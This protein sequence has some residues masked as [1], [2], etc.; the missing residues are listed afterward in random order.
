MSQYLCCQGYNN[1][2]CCLKP[3]R[4]CESSCPCLCLCIE[5]H[6]CCPVMYTRYHV[7]DMNELQ[8]DPCDNRLIWCNNCC[9]C[10][11][12]KSNTILLE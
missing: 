11:S 9:Q 8:N 2:C 6:F 1:G 3:G 5:S 10:A 7:M 12:C 4:L